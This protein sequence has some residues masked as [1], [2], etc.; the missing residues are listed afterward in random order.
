MTLNE[1][2]TFKFGCGRYHQEKNAIEAYLKEEAERFGKRA[3]ILAGE[4]GYR[5]AHEKIANALRGSAVSYEFRLFHSLPCPANAEDL[6]KEIEAGGF[7]L[8]IGVGGGV[9]MDQAKLLAHFANLPLIQIP[10]SSATCAAVT[11]LSV[12]YDRDTGKTLGSLKLPKEADAV[13]VDLE[14]LVR[15][16]L[17]LFAA[18]VM[19]AMAK[20][21]EIE[22]FVLFIPPEK[23]IIG[24]DYAYQLACTTTSHLE[25]MTDSV[26]EDMKEGKIS[27]AFNRLIFDT[28]AVTGIISG[29]SKNQNQTAIAHRFYEECRSFFPVETRPFL[30][31]ELVALGLLVQTE[32]NDLDPAPILRELKHMKL[33]ASLSEIGID[34]QKGMEVFSRELC[35][36]NVID[37]VSPAS[38]ARVQSALSVI[39]K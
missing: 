17:R 4:N 14:I 21:I 9:L 6:K 33:P 34:P 13:L 5:V 39:A 26:L 7:D 10:T 20:K 36:S 29:I 37:N 27:H 35:R 8:V 32:Y 23:M 38:L 28:V 2:S 12:M 22:H 19:D 15:Q 24:L 25:S 31:G 18:G 3:F 16:P 30:H 11:P 1:D